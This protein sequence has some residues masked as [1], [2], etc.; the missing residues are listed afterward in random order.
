MAILGLD[1]LL[2]DIRLSI[3]SHRIAALCRNL[4]W[5]RKNISS[6]SSI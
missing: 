6:G 1:H 3:G 2:Q 5:L 4:H